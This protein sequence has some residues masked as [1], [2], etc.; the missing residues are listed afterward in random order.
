MSYV[1]CCDCMCYFK[2]Y[3]HKYSCEVDTLLCDGDNVVC[4]VCE[5][6]F[7]HDYTCDDTFDG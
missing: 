2:K 3:S 1:H 5:D 6:E 4:V 7:Y